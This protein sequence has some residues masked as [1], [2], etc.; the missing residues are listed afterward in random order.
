M[1]KEKLLSVVRFWLI[2]TFVIVLAATTVYVTLFNHTSLIEAL[3]V[4]L[5]I[6]GI[7]GILCIVWYLIYRVYLNNKS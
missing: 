4:S 1:D 3:G 6:W 2:G 7:T 5:P